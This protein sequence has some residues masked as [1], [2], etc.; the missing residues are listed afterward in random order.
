M[1]KPVDPSLPEEL[2][3]H[4]GGA[5]PG[6]GAPDRIHGETGE[7]DEQFQSPMGV[8]GMSPGGGSY[9]GTS[10]A[11]QNPAAD[12]GGVPRGNQ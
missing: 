7:P 2:D 8:A 10:P 3:E 11:D 4:A 6:P 12:P 1:T 5:D 9:G